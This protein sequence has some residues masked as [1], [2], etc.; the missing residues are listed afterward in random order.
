MLPSLLPALADLSPIPANFRAS[1]A[2]NQVRKISPRPDVALCELTR[3]YTGIA[4]LSSMLIV[5][6]VVRWLAW[7]E[8]GWRAC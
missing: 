4:Y 3:R 6:E 8:M 7:L 2:R 5:L 1:R